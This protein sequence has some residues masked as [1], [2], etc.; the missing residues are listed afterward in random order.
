MKRRV[1]ILAAALAILGVA[2]SPAA[3]RP[4]DSA[5]SSNW[6]GY[7]VSAPNASFTD[8]K[9]SWVQPTATCTAGTQSYS[10]FWIGLGGSILGSQGLEQTGTSSDCQ[11]DGEA[12]TYAWYE[13]IPAPPVIVPLVV[14]P[15]DA[16]TGEVSVAGTTATFTLDDTTTGQTYTT[17]QTVATPDLTSAEWIAEAPA[18]CHTFH[19][20]GG[21]T[22]LPLANFGVVQF[23]A[24]STTL[25]GYTGTISDPTWSYTTI[26]LGGGPDTSAATPSDLSTDGTSF[27]VSW[28]ATAAAPEHTKATAKP[29]A[30]PKVKAKP[31][32][33]KKPKPKP[34]AKPKPSKAT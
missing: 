8:V 7:S 3:A 34:K 2:A 30:K 23:S 25:N 13:I 28:I 4:L 15:G 16:I 14:S 33:K 24:A 11:A 1:S 32:P 5:V 19:G 20:G 17:Q 27:S 6:A 12:T 9:G 29:K 31:K 21:C 26:S 10:S 22:V 18:Q